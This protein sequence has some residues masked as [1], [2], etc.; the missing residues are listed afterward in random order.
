MVG[1]ISVLIMI[2]YLALGCTPM[3]EVQGSQS[4]S[5]N[6][7]G[8]NP[9]GRN[10]DPPG[11]NPPPDNP[12]PPPNP[13]PRPVP[14][15]P[16]EPPVVVDPRP[17]V[18]VSTDI[19]GSDPDDFQSMVHLFVVMDQMQIQGLISSPPSGGRTA[20]IHEVIDAYARDYPK[21]KNHGKFPTA[22]YLRDVTKQGAVQAASSRGWDG[23]TQGSNWIVSKAKE[24]HPTP[25]YVLVWGS[26][27]DVA[28]AVHDAPEIKSN[29]RVY[30]IGS[31]NT[32][33]DKS[34]RN[35]LYNSHKDMW[36]VEADTTFRGMYQGGNQ[37]GE[38]GNTEF[39]SRNVR[40]HGHLG[41][42]FYRK[43]RDIKMG[44]T[45]SVL[46]MVNGDINN[47]EGESWGG[48]FRKTGHGANYW[49]DRT[50]SSLKY[51]DYNGANTVNKWRLQYLQDW[52][53]RMDWIR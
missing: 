3:G 13:I 5:S 16:P 41:D 22:E 21:I 26:I 29:L 32:L 19:G 15:P 28:Q 2:C 14:I 4:N 48:R 49:H 8:D 40:A 31:W 20:D 25:V 17:H 47:P 37:S 30:S 46:Y 27:T 43:K 24:L 36:W 18:I 23:P 52:K 53:N 7:S 10:P 45:P 42:L 6:N 39:V 9:L 33:K 34:S 1:Y 51:R 38:W 11:G 50:E 44:D 12:T 35:Y